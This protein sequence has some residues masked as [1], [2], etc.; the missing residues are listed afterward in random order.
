MTPNYFH[1]ILFHAATFRI[2]YERSFE[3]TFGEPLKIWIG[4][5]PIVFLTDPRDIEVR[6][7]AQRFYC[8]R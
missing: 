6:V 4:P 2:L 3:F 1:C 5:R 8:A 7:T